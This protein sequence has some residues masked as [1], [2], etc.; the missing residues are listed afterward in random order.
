MSV[1]QDA[2]R[3]ACANAIVALG[4]RIGLYAGGT[5][6]GTVYADT[7]WGAAAKISEAINPAQPVSGSNPVVDKAQSVGSTVTISVPAST[8]ANGTV[9]DRYGVFNGT[10]LL[11]TEALPISLTIND[12]SQ[13]FQVDVTPTYKYRG[14]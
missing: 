8:V 4:A 9:I 6:V 2:H 5:R 7:T 1:Y 13:A 10:T 12:G 11:R 14:E 3:N